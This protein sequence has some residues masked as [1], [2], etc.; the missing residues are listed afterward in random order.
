MGPSRPLAEKLAA[1]VNRL[2]QTAMKIGGDAASDKLMAASASAYPF[3]EAC[4]DIIMSWMLL[5]R[6]VIAQQAVAG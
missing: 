5:W 2:A 1:A 4:G 3:M 6:A